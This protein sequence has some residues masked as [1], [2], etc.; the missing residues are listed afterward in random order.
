ME[1]FRNW[2]IGMRSWREHLTRTNAGIWHLMIQK[3]DLTEI[4]YIVPHRQAEIP[5]KDCTLISIISC[6]MIKMSQIWALLRLTESWGH[7]EFH[8]RPDL[9]L[10]PHVTSHSVPE[11]LKKQSAKYHLWLYDRFLLLCNLQ[12]Y[13]DSSR[14]CLWPMSNLAPSLWKTM[15]ASFSRSTTV[16]WRDSISW[17]PGLYRNS[18]NWFFMFNHACCCHYPA[19]ISLQAFQQT[20]RPRVQVPSA[21]KTANWFTRPVL[22]ET[23]AK[24]MKFYIVWAFVAGLV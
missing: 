22:D 9:V 3:T 6:K 15:C 14:S 16:R 13:I 4:D 5:S 8:V 1:F 24:S 17:S 12:S 21:E 11:Q 2:R 7:N 20:S 19:P 18:L 23:L 10:F